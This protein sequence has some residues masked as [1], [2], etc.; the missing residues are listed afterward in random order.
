MAKIPCQKRAILS[1]RGAFVDSI[2]Y[3][4][5]APG[6]PAHHTRLFIVVSAD[7]IVPHPVGV[8]GIQQSLNRR[9]VALGDESLELVSSRN[10]SPLGA[11]GAPSAGHLCCCPSRL[12][13]PSAPVDSTLR[14]RPT[15]RIIVTHKSLVKRL[16]GGLDGSAVAMGIGD[17]LAPLCASGRRNRATT[18]VRPAACASQT[19][20]SYT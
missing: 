1:A 4:Q 11:S 15:S 8:A 12:L 3:S 17:S 19:P 5:L 20:R 6:Y 9:L 16:R 7:Q 14:K 2:R 13:T 18:G 10:R